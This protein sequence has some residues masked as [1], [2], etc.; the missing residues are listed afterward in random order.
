M[1]ITLKEDKTSGKYYKRMYHGT[2]CAYW[3]KIEK[4][5]RDFYYQQDVTKIILLEEND[6][7]KIET[8]FFYYK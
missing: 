7:L 4:E 8:V 6:S 5:R 2:P 1:T 3:E